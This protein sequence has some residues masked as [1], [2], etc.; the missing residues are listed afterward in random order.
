MAAAGQEGPLE[1]GPVAK[2]SLHA[3]HSS[4][5]SLPRSRRLAGAIGAV[6]LAAL[7]VGVV[8][9]ADLPGSSKGASRTNATGAATVQRRDLVAT[10][11]ESGTIGYANPQ[12]VYNRLTGTITS[13]PTV[14][15]VIKQGQT[16]YQ[17]D[18]SPVVL[19]YGN[20]PAYRDLNSSVSSGPDVQE[21]NQDLVNLGFDPNH[22]ITVN[23]TW[24]AATTSAV[25]SWQAS[26]GEAQT[27]TITLGQIAFLPG[28]QRVTSVQA[29]LG[30]TGSSSGG[31]S[32][33]GASSSGTSGSGASGTGTSGSGGSG[34]SGSS[35]SSGTGTSST[36]TS[37]PTSGP[38][39]PQP[40]FVSLS[41]SGSGAPAPSAA[42]T[43]ASATTA[44]SAQCK[45]SKGQLLPPQA[46][47][48]GSSSTSAAN[49]QLAVLL[50]LLKA[51]T[52]ELQSQ[53]SRSSSSAPSGASAARPS[54]ASSSARPSGAPS[55]ASS[56]GRSG[57]SGGAGAGG[58]AGTS[59]AS[60][61]PNA[62]PILQTTSTQPVVTVNL[63]AT[64]QTE[65]VVGEPVTVQMPDGSNRNGKITNVSPVAQTS[66]SSS[67]SSSSGAAGGASSTPSSVVPITIAITGRHNIRGMDQAAVSVNF[68]QQVSKNVLSVPVTALIATAGGSYAVQEATAPHALIPVTPGLFAAGFVQVS[69]PGVYDGLQVTDSQG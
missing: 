49:M 11:T 41:T 21:L 3:V 35:S 66:S 62:Q 69:G 58:G 24:Q 20:T 30:S 23:N 18:N 27:G 54:G 10:D 31:G 46:C 38:V 22:Q 61:P 15:Q 56:A 32:G 44:A 13:L 40:E 50:A 36:G 12:T 7:A 45:G 59:G 26:V 63:D 51:E 34:S 5:V 6:T 9:G 65:A 2:R 42:S 28:S 67:S 39:T 8:L 52:A 25:E 19:F 48:I 68:E 37:A 17:V 43:D 1:E 33:S 29:A 14:G 47:H 60:T 4:L 16:L 55:S 57:T 64:K 53:R